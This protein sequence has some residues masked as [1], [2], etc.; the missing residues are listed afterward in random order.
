MII[1]LTDLMIGNVDYL[2]IDDDVVID[3]SYLDGT[4]IREL[5]GTHFYGNVTRMGDVYQ[6]KG[7]ISGIMVL[8]DDVTLLDVDYSFDVTVSEDFGDNSSD[9]L[10]IDQNKLDITD[11]LWQNI[12]VEV[13]SKV[14][15]QGNENLKLEGDG[16]RLVTEDDL[17]SSN[18]SPFSELS[19]MFDSGKE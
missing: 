8:P 11:F 4:S 16:W 1:D 3:N 2:T 17:E 15:K 10:K 6:L 19:K 5:I 12:L 18:D 7:I 9:I 13:P 14:R